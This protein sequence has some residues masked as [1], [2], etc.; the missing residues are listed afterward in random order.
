MKLAFS[1]LACPGWS[2]AQ[3]VEAAVRLGY[4][5]IEL[6]LLDGELIDPVAHRPRVARA[7][8]LCRSRHLDVCALDTSCRL[9]QPDAPDRDRQIADLLAWL[10]L[11]HDLQVPVLRVFGGESPDTAGQPMEHDHAIRRVVEALRLVADPAERAGVI[12]ALETHDAFAS[13]RRV[14]AVVDAIGS[15]HVAALW[16]G[17]HTFRMGES[18]QWVVAALGSSIALVH[19]KDARRPAPGSDEWQLTLLGEG[20]VPLLDQLASLHLAGYSGYVSVEWEK[21]WHPEIAEPELAL[22]QHIRWLDQAISRL[23]GDK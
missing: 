1:T 8:A 5:G 9:N 21:K 14:A 17:L 7:V 19:V 15:K 20:D 6:R 10:D 22:P 18:P 13:A 16:D 2:I 23:D 3:T 11:A 4:A 12:V